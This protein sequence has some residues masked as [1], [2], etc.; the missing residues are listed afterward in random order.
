MLNISPAMAQILYRI[1]DS[2]GNII[3]PVELN[4]PIALGLLES[5]KVR[6]TDKAGIGS[7]IS[8]CLPFTV[9]FIIAFFILVA[10]FYYFNLPL[11]PGAN[12][13]IN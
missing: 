2:S 10:I 5:Y 12:I 1:G 13:F 8:L 9:A 7:L 3:S 11:G 4:V 6:K